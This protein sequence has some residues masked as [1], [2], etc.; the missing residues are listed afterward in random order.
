LGNGGVAE[1]WLV[2]D[3]ET[4]RL[5]VSKRL[6]CDDRFRPAIRTASQRAH[7]LLQPLA[8]Y[9]PKIQIPYEPFWGNEAIY[10]YV[11]G[12]PL[13]QTVPQGLPL[14]EKLYL[15]KR[16]LMQA[17][18][19]LSELGGKGLVHCDVR[20]ENMVLTP[21]FEVF[22]IDPDFTI[23]AGAYPKRQLHGPVWYTA[24]EVLKGNPTP[25]SDLFSAG[26]SAWTLLGANLT[27]LPSPA[28]LSEERMEEGF[29]GTASRESLKKIRPVLERE[30]PEFVRLL[31]GLTDPN[32]AH[33]P[34]L[35]DCIASLREHVDETLYSLPN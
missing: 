8:D 35:S 15:V 14:E 1:A 18:D 22:L 4:G 6:I 5:M 28:V 24:P 25:T 34:I 27:V 30:D 12:T 7:A 29:Q 23:E 33:R 21:D 10:E 11:P 3:Q 17:V 20:P 19:A 16:R 9:R 31:D 26:V 2:Q 32:P 13:D